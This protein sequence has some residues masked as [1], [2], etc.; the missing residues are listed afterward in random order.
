MTAIN[1][2][3]GTLICKRTDVALT[4]PILLGILQDV[5]IDITQTNKELRGAYKMPFDVAPSDLKVSGKAKFAKIQS[6]GINN[7]LLGGTETSNAGTAMSVAEAINATGTSFSVAHTSTFVEDLGLYYASTLT[8]LQ[9]AASSV[10]A[11]N[12][13]PGAAGVGGYQIHASD[14]GNLIVYYSYTTTGQKNIALVNQLMGTGPVFEL[15]LQESYTYNGTGDAIFLKLPACRCTKWN[16]PFKNNDYTIQDF[17]F[18]AFADA[19]GNILT[20]CSTE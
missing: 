1:F 8:Q 14:E 12:Y 2:G 3:S 6:D 13:V 9:P 10:A 16:I 18:E 19:T 7:L 20:W 15:N 5:E 4:K 17:E 11:G